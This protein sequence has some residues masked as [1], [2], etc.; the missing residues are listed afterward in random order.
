MSRC[1]YL[2]ISGLNVYGTLHEKDDRK[3]AN[4]FCGISKVTYARELVNDAE[5]GRVAKQ[6]KTKLRHSYQYKPNME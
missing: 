3:E 2:K 1:G 6:Q 4:P 5:L